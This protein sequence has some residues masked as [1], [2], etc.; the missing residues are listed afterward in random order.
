MCVCVCVDVRQSS[1]SEFDL[2]TETYPARPVDNPLV[3]SVS[4]GDLCGGS[5]RNWGGY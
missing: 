3:L 5:D 2:D 1:W 4:D